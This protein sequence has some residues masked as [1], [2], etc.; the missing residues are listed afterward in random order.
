M[1]SSPAADA[2]FDFDLPA[3]PLIDALQHYGVLTRQPAL[4]RSEIVDGRTSAAVSGRYSAEEALHLLLGGTGLVA[5]RFGHDAGSAFVLRPM[6]DAKAD[7]TGVA[8]LGGMDGY[9][10]LIQTRV[11]QALCANSRTAPGR[12][13]S[14]LSFRVDASGQIQRVRLVVSSGDRERDA[15]L[16]DVL[17]RVRMGSTPPSDLAQPVAV[18]VLPHEAGAV[19]RCDQVQGGG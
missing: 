8:S 19:M 1:A 10:R 2:L 13:R 18:L 3:Q 15:A 9:P 7:G 4:F 6:L 14:L 11:W 12:Y 5:E 16:L 17:G